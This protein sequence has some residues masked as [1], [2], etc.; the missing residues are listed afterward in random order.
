MK[1]NDKQTLRS[2]SIEDLQSQVETMRAELLKGRLAGAVEGQGLGMRARKLR[3]DIARHL[4]YITQK[5]AK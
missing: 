3:R 4:T 1:R 5:T 2:K